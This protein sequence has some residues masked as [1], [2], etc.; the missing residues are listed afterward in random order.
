MERNGSC[1]KNLRIGMFFNFC[2]VVSQF[3]IAPFINILFETNRLVRDVF[4]R[5]NEGK[6]PMEK[7]IMLIW[8]FRDDPTVV[9]FMAQFVAKV[10]SNPLVIIGLV[11]FQLY[12]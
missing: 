1:M 4:G 10:R 6:V 7:V 5:D 3:S 9:K 11:S 8:V 2:N 12:Y